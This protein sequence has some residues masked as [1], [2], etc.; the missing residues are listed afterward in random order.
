MEKFN[1]DFQSDKDDSLNQVSL[2]RKR[3][4]T[5]LLSIL[6]F[7]VV[8]SAIGFLLW[9]ISLKWVTES[10]PNL[11]LF[12]GVSGFLLLLFEAIFAFFAVRFARQMAPKKTN[13]KDSL[14]SK[15]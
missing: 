9:F 13:K 2:S 8:F 5:Y 10:D 1:P 15:L 6:F 14:S 3:A 7:L 12:F 4:L 11:K